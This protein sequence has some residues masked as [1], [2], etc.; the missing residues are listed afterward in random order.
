[1]FLDALGLVSSAQQIT[2]D[3]TSTSSIDLG[4][5]TPKRAIG[6]GEP[7]G[8]LIAITAVGTTTGSAIISSISSASDTL[9]TA[10]KMNSIGLATADLALGKLHFVGIRP[11]QPILR[12]IG[13]DYDITG[14]VDFTVTA[15]LIPL[16]L[17]H[18]VTLQA[19]GYTVS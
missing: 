6:A 11:G 10:T 15:C 16:A 18:S 9:G 4:N 7:V 14:T 8:F 3:A 2:A 5:L 17:F 1:M 12:Y 19:K 13:L